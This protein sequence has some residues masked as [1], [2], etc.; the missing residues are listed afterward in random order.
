M[1]IVFVLQYTCESGYFAL[2]CEVISLKMVMD[3]MM[4][5]G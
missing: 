5:E 3:V 1:Y 2:V 4:V